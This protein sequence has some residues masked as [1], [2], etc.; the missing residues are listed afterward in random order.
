MKVLSKVARVNG[1]S[2]T[3]FSADGRTWSADLEDLLRFRLRRA[4]A[5]KGTAR[6]FARIG[7]LKERQKNEAKTI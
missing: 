6:L 3:V 1:V 5:I 7:S 2:V 4:E